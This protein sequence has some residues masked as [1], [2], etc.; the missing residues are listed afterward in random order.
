MA[1]KFNEFTKLT[2]RSAS[3]KPCKHGSIAEL[4]KVYGFPKP[5]A[6]RI[7]YPSPKRLSMSEL[8]QN[9]KTARACE[10][11]GEKNR[12]MC[13]S[14][15]PRPLRNNPCKKINYKQCKQVY[16]KTAC[17]EPMKPTDPY[18]CC[19]KITTCSKKKREALSPCP[20]KERRNAGHGSSHWV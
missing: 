12:N 5:H 15:V 9:C 1:S 2:V 7:Y 16:K 18:A 10:P 4:I 11:K 6:N 20:N 13:A 8:C 3:Q 14:V 19:P 17:T